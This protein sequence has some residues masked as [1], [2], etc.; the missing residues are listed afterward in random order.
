MLF[1]IDGQQHR[2]R[3]FHV[4]PA[5]TTLQEFLHGKEGD[6]GTQASLER[7]VNDKWEVIATGKSDLT[8]EDW[9]KYSRET[10]RKISLTRLTK[11]LYPDN[12]EKRKVIWDA[13]LNR[14]N[15]TKGT[16]HDLPVHDSSQQESDTTVSADS[17]VLA[18]A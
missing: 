2:L 14:K 18:E 1:E 15:T 9:F 11:Q 3:F 13:Y 7:L 4:N 16:S 12:A 8:V 6:F 17:R 10:G 5:Q